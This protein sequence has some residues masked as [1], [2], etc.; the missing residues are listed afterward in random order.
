M[1]ERKN[2]KAKS[3]GGSGQPPRQKLV[4][5]DEAPPQPK[6]GCC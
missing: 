2:E 3:S 1:L 5:V 4:I 6:S